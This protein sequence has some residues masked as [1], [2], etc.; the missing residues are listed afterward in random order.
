M[1][2]PFSIL[3]M[4]IISGIFLS[5][6]A[7]A[8][9]LYK[10]FELHSHPDNSVTVAQFNSQALAIAVLVPQDTH[11]DI[12]NSQSTPLTLVLAQSLINSQGIEVAPANSLVSAQLV[13]S[14]NGAQIIADSVVVNG[15]ALSIRAVSN[16]IP[17]IS[18]EASN[19]QAT[20]EINTNSLGRTGMAVGCAIGSFAGGECDSEAM[21]TGGSIGL[22]L[23]I[24]TN[25]NTSETRQIVQI[26]Q[27]TLFVLRAQ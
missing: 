22:V 27:G 4:S 15:R 16:V 23:G 25:Q 11:V 24:F 20:A 7:Y 26:P 13:P 14:G 3:G 5:S 17:S 1:K 10:D 6:S 18:V 19:Q 8:E 12:G 9:E 21:Q 2:V